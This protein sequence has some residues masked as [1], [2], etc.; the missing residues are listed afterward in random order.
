M[1]AIEVTVD[2]ST[3]PPTCN[4]DEVHVSAA[5]HDDGI[6]WVSQTSGYT[7]T[8]VTITPSPAGEFGAPSISTNANGMSVMTVTDSIT[9]Y[10]DHNYTL[11]Y[12]D[13]QGNAGAHDPKIKNDR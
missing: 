12:T 3:T 8:G 2:F 1:S 7:F 4:P 5:H 11:D 9:D 13:P 10:A 6:T